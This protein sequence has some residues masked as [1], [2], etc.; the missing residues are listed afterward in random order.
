MENVFNG[1]ALEVSC[2]DRKKMMEGGKRKLENILRGFTWVGFL[3]M[4]FFSVS[5]AQVEKG[6]ITKKLR[7]DAKNT[8]NEESK[9]PVGTLNEFAE[10]FSNV[11]DV[12]W[13]VEPGYSEAEF[14]R[15]N[16]AMMAFYNYDGELMGSG[17]YVDYADLP[18]KGRERI[19]KDYA[20]YTPQKAMFYEDDLDDDN[21]FLNFYGNFLQKDAYFVLLQKDTKEIVVQVTEN[22]EV[23]YFSNVRSKY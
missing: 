14:M 16:K 6:D 19:A 18:E 23:S 11:Q 13:K 17:Y 15:N 21:D 7:S 12:M 5:Y 20:D 9:I 1:H 3:T 2:E 4:I 22:G 8:M 10:D